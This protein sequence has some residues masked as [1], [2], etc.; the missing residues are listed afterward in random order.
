MI[1]PTLEILAGI[2]TVVYGF[3]AVIIIAP[4]LQWLSEMATGDRV[5]GTYSAGA[6]GIAV[7]IM[8]LPIVTSLSED[9]PAIG[10]RGLRDGAYALGSTRFDTSVRVVVPGPLAASWR[11]T[12]LPSRGRIGET[13]IVALAAGGRPRHHDPA[14]GPGPDHDGVHRADLPRRR[15][16]HRRRVQVELRGGGGALPR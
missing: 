9:A 16:G 3:F 5:F 2:P 8:I 11:P 4:S 13:M 14:V 1:K 10:A 15:P 6:A 7:G 12:S